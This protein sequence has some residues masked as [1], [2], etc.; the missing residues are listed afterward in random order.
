MSAAHG[1]PSL[2]VTRVAD[3]VTRAPVTCR[4]STTAME[5][6]RLL[7]REQVG[8]AVVVEDDGR[9]AGIVTDRDLRGKV[10]AAALDASTTTAAAIM[11][12]PVVTVRPTAFAFEALL[13]MTRGD[14]HHVPVA[15]GGRL[16]GVLSSNDFLRLH[17]THPVLLAR[18]IAAAPSLDS[19][20]QLA[21]RTTPLVRRLLDEG[22]RPYDIG[23]I[24][25]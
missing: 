12:S 1:E 22:G 2:F 19:L 5:V 3:L 8:S 13:E 21:S 11:S 4:P 25:A 9:L 24:V 20:A 17:T 18:E 15:D 16:V 10:V 14:I 7:T 23:Q 6:A